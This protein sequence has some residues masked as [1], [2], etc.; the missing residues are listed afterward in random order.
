MRGRLSFPPMERT[1]R[2]RGSWLDR[3]NFPLAGIIPRFTKTHLH[4][5]LAFPFK[6]IPTLICA[7]SLYNL[8]PCSAFYGLFWPLVAFFSALHIMFETW[9][10]VFLNS[11]WRFKSRFFIIINMALDMNLSVRNAAFPKIQP[12]N[13][14]SACWAVQLL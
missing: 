6:F 8:T 4:N 2:H 3:R 10:L 13:N 5:S 11:Y 14:I 7:I 9:N 1:S 12:T